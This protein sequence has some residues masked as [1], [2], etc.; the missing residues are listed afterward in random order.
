MRLH[1]S[2]TE[3]GGAPPRYALNNR[4]SIAE[5]LMSEIIP[6]SYDLPAKIQAPRSQAQV[7]AKSMLQLQSAEQLMVGASSLYY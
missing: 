7:A 2:V 4:H 6:R 5:K 3:L 1:G